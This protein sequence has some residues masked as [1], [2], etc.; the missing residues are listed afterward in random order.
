MAFAIKSSGK[1]FRNELYGLFGMRPDNP[2]IPVEVLDSEG[3]VYIFKT[4][5]FINAAVTN[6]DTLSAVNKEKVYYAALYYLA[7]LYYRFYFPNAV[8][9]YMSDSRAVFDKFKS[10]DFNA[11]AD[12]LIGDAAVIIEEVTGV[13]LI[14]IEIFSSVAPTTD[15]VT[16]ETNA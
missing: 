16:G 2:F 15:I 7:S 9:K 6:Y 14:D 13:S 12:R 10:T 5:S 4:D 8:P 1:P 11:I 3:A